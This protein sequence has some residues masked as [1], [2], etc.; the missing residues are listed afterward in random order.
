MVDKVKPTITCGEDVSANAKDN[1]TADVTVAAPKVSDN[2]DK[3]VDLSAVRLDTKAA[4]TLEGNNV[5]GNFPL[6]ETEIRWYAEDEAGNKDSCSQKVTVVDVTKP[7]IICS[8][9]SIKRYVPAGSC[10]WSGDDIP[11]PKFEDNC[12]AELT[13]TRS[14]NVVM[15]ISGDKVSTG[16]FKVGPT[17]ITWTVTD[18]AKLTATCSQILMVYDTIRPRITCNADVPVDADN[19]C[20][21]TGTVKAPSVTENCTHELKAFVVGG[22]TKTDLTISEGAVSYT[23]K[24]GENIIR[25]YAEDASGNKDSCDQK[26]KVED[27]ARPTITCGANVEVNAIASCK[28]LGT[29]ET[30]TYAD[31]CEIVSLNVTRDDNGSIEITFDEVNK[32]VAIDKTDSFAIG[33]VTTLT[34]T[35]SDGKNTNSCT[36]TIEVIDNEKPVI[37]CPDPISENTTSTTCDWTGDIDCPK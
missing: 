5:T 23:F 2:C 36:Q 12:S 3:S 15:T 19:K 11:L 27:N 31:N 20:Q 22:D 7:T 26:I 18:G 25:W 21:W 32:T 35:V 29:I 4:L 8:G 9:D 1:C 37:A 24:K 17:E 28:W 13:V 30:P 34:W 10:V 6:G 14:D 16:D 33:S